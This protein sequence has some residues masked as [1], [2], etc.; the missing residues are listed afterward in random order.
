MNLV[1]KIVA[2]SVCWT[3]LVMILESYQRLQRE[4]S[5]LEGDLVKEC[6]IVTQLV[7]PKFARILRTEGFEATQP[8]LDDIN[9]EISPISLRV[10]DI[11]AKNPALL[12]HIRQNEAILNAVREPQLAQQEPL[13]TSMEGETHELIVVYQPLYPDSPSSMYL[14]ASVSLE[15]EE[16]FIERAIF[17]LGLML[18]VIILTAILF[19]MWAGWFIIG[20]RI[21]EMIEQA[22]DAA[23]GT[24]RM[25]EIPRVDDEITEL[26]KELNITHEAL[27]QSQLS[28]QEEQRRR[29]ELTSQLIHM[30]RLAMA[31]VMLA[32]I[33]HEIG[34]PLGVVRGRLQRALK[35]IQKP[36][37]A[38]QEIHIATEQVDRIQNIIRGMLD[39][40][41]G[42]SEARTVELEKLLENAMDL[43]AML[44]NHSN[45]QINL[46][47]QDSCTLILDPL[48]MEQ[49]LLNVMV[50]ALHAST[51]GSSIDICL[52]Q[53]QDN[54]DRTVA[55]V[56][57]TDHGEGIPKEI[58]DR[59]FD[60]FFTTKPSGKGS[61]MGL[62]IAST[63]V[64][65]FQ[66]NLYLDTDY[67][68]GARFIFDLP[69]HH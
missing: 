5:L 13:K 21:N 69:L 53:A 66:G 37:K 61:G 15:Q 20:K 58:A 1:Q 63:V 10:V 54:L 27:K 64:K 65:A 49:A 25:L 17:D 26:M 42:Q 36:E 39:F 30:D 6:T 52:S 35:H 51:Q 46:E 59:I 12:P 56:S 40:T 16:D 14:E 41:R 4:L 23:K 29:E 8:H 50:N 11:N 48:I 45:V 44:A 19:S 60:P 24:Y 31:G 38:T 7:R 47:V 9:R 57:I 68:D 43:I 32:Q 28:I 18:L 34:T 33:S 62:M 3:S 55:R 22:Q 2:V 67:T